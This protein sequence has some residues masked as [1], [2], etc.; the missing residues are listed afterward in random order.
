M[1][2]RVVKSDLFFALEVICGNGVKESV[3]VSIT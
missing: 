3:K 2:G 1:N